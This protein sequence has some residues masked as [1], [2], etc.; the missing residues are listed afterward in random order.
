[1]TIYDTSKTDA[2]YARAQELIPGGIFGHYRTAATRVGPKFFSRADGARFWDLDGNEYID[3]MCAYGPN[4]LGYNHP[5]VDAAA[6]AQYQQGNTVSVAAPVMVELAE[7]LVDMVDAADWAIFGKNGGDATS[8]AVRVARAA[9]GR[10]KI[11]KVRDGYHGVAPWMM[12]SMPDDAIKA[13]ILPEDGAH[14][15]EV[16]WNDV[17]GFEQLISDH[18]A[19]I[20]CFISSPYDHPVLRDNEL[21]AEGYWQAIES[22]CRANGIVLIVDDVRAGFRIDL[23]GSNVAYG[24]TPDLICLG[25]AIANGYP[26]SA[27]VGADALKQSAIDVFYTGTQF[28]NA[29]PMAAA[30]AT[31][32][33]LAKTDGARR[34]TDIGNS[35]NA[36]LVRVAQEHGYE[37]VASGVPAMPYYRLADVDIKDHFAWIDECV[38]RGIY[39]LGFHN[40]FLSTAHTDADL[41]TT[42]AR[43]SDAFEA[44]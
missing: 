25:K 30:K 24:F 3:Y 36:G 14:L 28:F 40:H 10:P 11:V 17:A 44:L 1:M 20:A 6:R 33:E 7:V 19:D 34:M 23:A 9:T 38:K 21:A 37:L 39:L 35:L 22:L 43:V 4:I 15:L 31:L 29:A 2:M 8:L 27:L 16:E 13:G 18:G 41:E 42:W 5:V 26:L 32:G 12:A